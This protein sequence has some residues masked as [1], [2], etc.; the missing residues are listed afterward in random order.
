MS[1]TGKHIAIFAATGAI[2]GEVARQSA[3]AGAHVDLS[4]R[5]AHALDTLAS[6]ITESGGS[7]SVAVVDA[8][9]PAA[10]DA[11]V[12]RLAANGGIDAVFNGIGPRAAEAHYATPSD[13]ISLD[14]F[15]FPFDLIVGSTFLT[16][17]ATARHMTAQGHGSIITLSASLSGLTTPFMAGISA[18]CGGIEA[19]T[20]SLAGEYGPAGVRVNCVRANAMPETR[21]IQETG[22][23]MAQN[24][25]IDMM[26]SPAVSPLR[27]PVSIADTAAAV[28]HLASDSS[29]MVTAQ[30]LN[31]CG[32]VLV[33]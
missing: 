12:D 30:V 9:D 27:Q 8:T 32:G 28:I 29:R 10:V 24:L 22:A 11:Y 20:R 1:L 16:S 25:G 3:A 14:R 31:V 7:T 23:Q 33:D 6:Q 18:A 2:A 26:M 21:T 4:G 5:D 19:M 13:V 17:R 15:L